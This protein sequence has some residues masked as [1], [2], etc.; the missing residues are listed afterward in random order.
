MELKY[1]K[2][3]SLNQKPPHPGETG[4]MLDIHVMPRLCASV[5]PYTCCAR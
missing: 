2:I 4:S 3:K 5:C 1:K